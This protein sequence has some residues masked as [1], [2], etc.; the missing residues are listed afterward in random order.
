MG[1]TSPVGST[2]SS[3]RTGMEIFRFGYVFAPYPLVTYYIL[4]GTITE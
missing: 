1:M 3:A 2:H 4:N